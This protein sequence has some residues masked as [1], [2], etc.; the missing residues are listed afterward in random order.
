VVGRYAEAVRSQASEL[1]GKQIDPNAP[2]VNE[3]T[4]T[5]HPSCRQPPLPR[6]ASGK[7]PSSGSAT[8][9]TTP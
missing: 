9:A 3:T 8:P 6:P 7:S 2:K 1:R 5:G 4:R